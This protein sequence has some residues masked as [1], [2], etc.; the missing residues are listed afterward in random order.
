MIW[1]QKYKNNS[2]T[3]RFCMAFW[4][5]LCLCLAAMEKMGDMAEI[6]PYGRCPFYRLRL[7][8]A[9]AMSQR[10]GCLTAPMS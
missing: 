5:N 8:L 10:P 7:T 3:A 9:P 4:E 6:P 1:L 2:I